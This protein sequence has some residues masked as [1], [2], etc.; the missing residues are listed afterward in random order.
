MKVPTGVG[1][2]QWLEER[3]Q[4]ER[5]SLRQAAEKTGLSHST[6]ADIMKGVRPSAETIR[7]LS[8]AFSGDGLRARLVLE[9]QLLVLAGYRT[10]R[11]EEDE[12]NLPLAQLIDTL[13]QFSEPQLRLTL[14]FAHFLSKME[15]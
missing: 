1:L 6:I 13:S 7:K 9:D 2:G 15:I 12:T 10:P 8:E 4:E 5:M 11:P 14:Q 3:C